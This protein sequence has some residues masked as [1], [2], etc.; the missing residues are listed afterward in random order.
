MIQL[1]KVKVFVFVFI[2]AFVVRIFTELTGARF[3]GAYGAISLDELPAII[4]NI[5]LSSIVFAGFAVWFLSLGKGK[6][7]SEGE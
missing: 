7:N 5:F 2:S 6:N 1:G 3:T 4:P